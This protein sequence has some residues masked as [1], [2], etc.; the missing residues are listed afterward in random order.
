[1][2]VQGGGCSGFQYGLMID[3][4]EGDATTDAVIEIQRRQAA[5]RSDQRALPAR[6]PKWISSTTS[7]AAASRSRTRTPSRPAAAA[8]RSACSF[9]LSEAS[10]RPSPSHDRFRRHVLAVGPRFPGPRCGPFHLQHH[11][12]RHDRRQRAAAAPRAR[13]RQSGW[14]PASRSAPSP[15]VATCTCSAISSTPASAS[16]ARVPR[17]PARGSDP[18]RRRDGRAP[19]RRSAAPIDVAPILADAGRAARASAGRRSRPRCCPPATSRRVT[20]RSID[21]WSSRRACVRPASRRVS[22]GGHRHHPRRRRHRVARASR[23]DEARRPDRR[24]S[25]PPASTRSR[26]VHSD[27]DAA[28]EARYRALAAELGLL[29]TGGSDFHGDAGHRVSRLGRS[30]RLRIRGLRRCLR[31]VAHV[32]GS[33]LSARDSSGESFAS[34]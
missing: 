4:G 14:S 6:A 3:E 15:R 20:R 10:D 13:C 29:V 26:R 1:M 33:R 22:R 12:S 23:R 18:P 7:P 24:R 21:S 16:S 34:S 30:S 11:R 8:L 32:G 9:R 25:P 17:S 5:G 2:F 27:H 28:T 31:A 19:R